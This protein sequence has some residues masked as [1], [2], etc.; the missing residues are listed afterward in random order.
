MTGRALQMIQSPYSRG[1]QAKEVARGVNSMLEVTHEIRRH[2]ALTAQSMRISS[3]NLCRCRF[4]SMTRCEAAA[5]TDA[6]DESIGSL[7]SA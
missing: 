4:R 2:F 1:F 3:L 7:V 5:G 6:S